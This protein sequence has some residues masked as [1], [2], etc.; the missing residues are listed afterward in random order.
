MIAYERAKFGLQLDINCSSKIVAWMFWKFMIIILVS[1]N[2][3]LQK[4]RNNF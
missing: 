4:L 1:F 3:E 2:P